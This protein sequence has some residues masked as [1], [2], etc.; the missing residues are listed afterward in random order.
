MSAS[1]PPR[2]SSITTVAPILP[3]RTS[4]APSRSRRATLSISSSPARRTAQPFTCSDERNEEEKTVRS[5]SSAFLGLGPPARPLR[6]WP[7][8]LGRRGGAPSQRGR[9]AR[10]ALRAFLDRL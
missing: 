7:S 1:A 5:L 4:P 9:R 6:R 3:P 8:P 10:S 2:Q